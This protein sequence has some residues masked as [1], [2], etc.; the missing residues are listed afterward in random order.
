MAARWSN[1]QLI[2]KVTLQFFCSLK[3]IYWAEH[4]RPILILKPCYLNPNNILRLRVRKKQTMSD[5]LRFKCPRSVP[6]KNMNFAMTKRLQLISAI[7]ILFTV[8]MKS[9]LLNK[10]KLTAVLSLQM[11]IWFGKLKREYTLSNYKKLMSRTILLI[12]LIL[13]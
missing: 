10:M 2:Y 6:T 13:N 5:S 7:S 8:S 1:L 3:E 11:T 4:F 12:N 9:T